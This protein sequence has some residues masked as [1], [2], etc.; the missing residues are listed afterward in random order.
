MF[1]ILLRR[2]GLDPATSSAPFIASLVDVLGI[3]IYMYLAKFVLAN[4]IAEA[5]KA[6]AASGH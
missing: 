3:L 4:V 5:M 6:K 1:P 2:L